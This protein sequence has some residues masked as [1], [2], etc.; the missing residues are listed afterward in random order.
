MTVK[1]AKRVA[2]LTVVG[3]T[4]ATLF[5]LLLWACERC[6]YKQEEITRSL[7]MEKTLWWVGIAVSGIFIWMARSITGD[8]LHI[9]LASRAICYLG[10]GGMITFSLFLISYPVHKTGLSIMLLLWDFIVSGFSIVNFLAIRRLE[11]PKP[12]DWY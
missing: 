4:C 9:R 7:L 1:G 11:C 5:M 12:T 10:F 6:F 2:L 8:T 3:T